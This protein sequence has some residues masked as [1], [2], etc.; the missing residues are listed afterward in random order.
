MLGL[1]GR[2]RRERRWIRFLL[3]RR[4]GSAMEG[5]ERTRFYRVVWEVM[6]AA[7]LAAGGKFI[8]CSRD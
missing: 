5:I 2:D 1:I 4:G 6:S 3:F 7:N 8:P